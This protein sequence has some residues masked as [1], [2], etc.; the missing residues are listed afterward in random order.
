[1]SLILDALNRARQERDGP[2]PTA[3]PTTRVD[4]PAPGPLVPVLASALVLAALVIGWL[5]WERWGGDDGERGA[6]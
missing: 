6:A 4:A 1:M 2:V 3:L 5:A